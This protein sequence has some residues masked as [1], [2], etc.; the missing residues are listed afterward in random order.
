MTTWHARR[1]RFIE[2]A[3]A[4]SAGSGAD[5]AIQL[6]QPLALQLIAII[7][8]SG[9]N[10]LYA[11]SLHLSQAAFPWLPRGDASP[12]ADYRF[13]DLKVSLEGQSPS[14]AN[15]AS[16]ML[17]LTFTNILASLIGEGLTT[18]ILNSAW[19]DDASDRDFAGKESQN[20]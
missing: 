16:Q 6:W 7:G 4:K 3:M 12:S 19:G 17:L 11:R 20:E 13:T 2:T 9:F 15:R 18:G 14:E 5:V 10:H 1:Q 8:E